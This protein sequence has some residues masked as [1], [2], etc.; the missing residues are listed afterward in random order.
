MELNKTSRIYTE[1]ELVKETPNGDDDQWQQF[2]PSSQSICAYTRAEV[3]S[4]WDVIG[5][6]TESDKL[7]KEIEKLKDTRLAIMKMDRKVNLNID[8]VRCMPLTILSRPFFIGGSV[9]RYGDPSFAG[10]R[11]PL[12]QN[13]AKRSTEGNLC[14]SPKFH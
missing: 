4:A 13:S 3:N 9:W 10:Y 11:R 1:E 12:P 5:M 8:A 2:L 14:C 6:G 7:L